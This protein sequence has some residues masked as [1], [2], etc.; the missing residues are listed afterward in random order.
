MTVGDVLRIYSRDR[1]EVVK[2]IDIPE[3]AKS[4]REWAEKKVQKKVRH[5]AKKNV[6]SSATWPLG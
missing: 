5:D 3:L 6:S 2:L 1:D 4:W